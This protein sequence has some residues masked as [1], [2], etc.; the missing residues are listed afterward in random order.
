M[1]KR[2]R[3]KEKYK[4]HTFRVIHDVDAQD[5]LRSNRC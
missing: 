4:L 3:T 2:K 1:R 5:V